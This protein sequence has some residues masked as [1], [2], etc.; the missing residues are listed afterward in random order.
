MQELNAIAA[1]KVC[2][3]NHK[4]VPKQFGAS[5]HEPPPA[6]SISCDDFGDTEIGK[7][8]DGTS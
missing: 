7:M 2:G 8:P 6:A 4:L 3:G 1:G 5:F